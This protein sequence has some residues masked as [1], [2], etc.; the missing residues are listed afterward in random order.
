MA[1]KKYELK[2]VKTWDEAVALAADGW[3][4]IAVNEGYDQH[5]APTRWAHYY[6]ERDA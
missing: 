2:C 4:L 3:R 5:L 1:A 6:F